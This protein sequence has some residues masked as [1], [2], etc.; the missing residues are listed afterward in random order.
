MSSSTFVIIGEHDNPLYELVWSQKK[1]E[2]SVNQQNQFHLHAALD[3]VDEEIWKNA[4][5]YGAY[6]SLSPRRGV[7]VSFLTANDDS[8]AGTSRLLT[9]ST[10]GASQRT[11]R[12]RVTPQPNTTCYEHTICSHP[13]RSSASVVAVAAAARDPCAR[14]ALQMQSS[15][16]CTRGNPRIQC[17]PSSMRHANPD[18][19]TTNRSLT[20]RCGRGAHCPVPVAR[21]RRSDVV[22][23]RCTSCISRRC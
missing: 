4:S 21:R 20:P 15:C 9:S 23:S 14:R 7:G 8:P 11:S 5:L 12:R 10:T 17:A 2:P 6:T 13:L 3:I 19:H 18:P 1:E 22:R 16:F